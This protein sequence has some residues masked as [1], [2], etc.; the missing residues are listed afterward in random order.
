MT[1]SKRSLPKKGHEFTIEW[2][3]EAVAELHE[4]EAYIFQFSVQG[5]EQTVVRILDA[6]ESLHKN[7]HRF[8]R[9]K[10]LSSQFRRVLVNQ[11]K[12]VFE[13]DENRRV[14]K[15]LSVWNTKWNPDKF[16]KVGKR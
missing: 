13:I 12:I 7:P 4:I 5:A 14:V 15:I 1:K 11:Y 10:E 16:L 9:D 8:Q 3:H 2:H 6:V